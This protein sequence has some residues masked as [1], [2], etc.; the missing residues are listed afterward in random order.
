M[1]LIKIN[2]LAFTY[3]TGSVTALKDINLSIKKGDFITVCGK[4]GCG[5]TTL[6]RLLKPSVAPFG[7]IKGTLLYKDKELSKITELEDASKI[8]FVMQNPDSQL[9]TEKVWTE[10]SFGLE[11][12]GYSNSEIRTRVSEMVSFFGI[13]DIFY[14]K[15][16]ELSGGQ[17]QIVN[18][19]SILVMQPEVLILD[20]PTSQLDPVCASDFIKTLEKINREF[21]ITVILSEHRLEEAFPVS[22][23]IIVM[24]NSKIICDSIP[25]KAGRILKGNDMFNALPA[26]VK[27]FYSVCDGDISPVTIKEGKL[28]LGEALK[29]P[30]PVTI[31]KK[32]NHNPI[33]LQAKDLWFKYESSDSY[34]IK[35][36]DLSVKKGEFFTLLGGNG[37]GKST[38]ISLLSGLTDFERGK[39][40]IDGKDIKK[41]KGLYDNFISVLPQN[42]L[43]TFSENTVLKDIKASLLD[44][45]DEEINEAC[46]TFGLE[47]LLD[48]HP[49]DLSGGEQQRLSLCKVFLRKSKI[50]FLDEPTKGLDANFKKTLA[51]LI[52]KLTDNDVTVIMVSHDIEFSAEY[53]SRCA[54]FFDGNVTS[55]GEPYEFF[56]DKFFYTTG[57]NKLARDIIPDAI[58]T[59]DIINAFS[60]EGENE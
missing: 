36:V 23:R 31:P 6:L 47:N 32:E 11:S 10:L 49:Y 22:D 60:K 26:S 14:K 35:G 34:V 40:T 3:K 59:K 15:T 43:L 53:A 1:E 33:F 45:T 54:L 39:I 16:S 57:A 30:K 13:E 5:K 37:A 20:E 9:I 21:S 44:V 24:E 52:K 4:S 19:A 48:T 55:I 51:E 28:W 17:K 27:A 46:K 41:H 25:Q 50:V 12:L 2:N 38:L 42:T 29:N 7:E 58:L 18:L 8:G 56:K